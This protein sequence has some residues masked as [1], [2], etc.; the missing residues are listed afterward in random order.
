[1]LPAAKK[2]E[3]T[4]KN[5]SVNW[6]NDNE[7]QCSIFTEKMWVQVGSTHAAWDS[8]QAISVKC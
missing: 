3:I 2:Y 8:M 7:N 1:M 4:N 6:D 5:E